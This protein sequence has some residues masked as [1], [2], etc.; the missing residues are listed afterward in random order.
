MTTGDDREDAA[1]TPEPDGQPP[2]PSYSGSPGGRPPTEQPP[3]Y[4]SQHP[5][6]AY[7]PFGPPR[8]P[9]AVTALVLGGASVVLF[10]PLGPFAWHIGA[11]AG[12]EMA[13]AP[14]RWSGDDLAKIGM[15]LGIVGSVL[16]ALFVL[17]FVLLLLIGVSFSGFVLGGVPG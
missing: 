5:Y 14:G 12:R 1:A 4:Q 8:H 16:C 11:K 6:A 15:V 2:P 10:P 13:A 9:E 3:P 7:P 17:F